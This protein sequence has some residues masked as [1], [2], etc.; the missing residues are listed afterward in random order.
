MG[1]VLGR[2]QNEARAAGKSDVV[3]RAVRGAVQ[4]PAAPFRSAG[5]YLSNV[6]GSVGRATE[7][8]RENERL[9]QLAQAAAMY[10]ETIDA[11]RQELEDARKLA[12]LPQA[13]GRLK[14]PGRVIGFYPLENRITLDIGTAKQVKAGLPVVA[15]DGLVGI[16]QTADASSCQVQL[17]S[18]PPPFRIGAKVLRDPPAVGLLYG[19]SLD[20]LTVEF[21]D[22]NAPIEVGDWIVTSGLSAMIPADIP[23][24]RVV[25]VRKDAEFGTRAAQVFPAVSLGR[26]RDVVVLR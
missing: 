13:V 24:G 8:E 1:V 21:V 4:G 18:S 11:L 20:R 6:A 19:E 25:Q 12:N 26:V 22:L 3:T 2:V 5:D 9:R 16:V 23:I 7:L 14:I 15:A 17:L 10:V